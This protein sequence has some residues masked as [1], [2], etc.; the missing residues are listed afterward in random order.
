MKLAKQFFILTAFSFISCIN[1]QDKEVKIKTQQLTEQVYMLT[2]QGDNIDFFV[3]E[4][5]LFRATVYKS[6]NAK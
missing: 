4:N 2:G 6:L 3:E 1:T 5:D